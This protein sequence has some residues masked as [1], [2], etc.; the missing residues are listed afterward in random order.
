MEL[1]PALT[2]PAVTPARVAAL[3]ETITR[4]A[5]L[6]AD[7]L[8]ADAELAAFRADTGHVYTAEEFLA[9]AHAREVAEFAREVARP[10]WLRVPDITRDELVEIVRRVQDGGG[11]AEFYLRLLEANV[12][13]PRVADLIFYPAD[14]DDSPERVV[15]EA[16]RYRPIEL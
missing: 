12:V 4:I 9:S 6:L 1:R 10:A 16:L 5:A 15:D 8:P 13:H 14:D 2:P 7:G 3:A 11:D